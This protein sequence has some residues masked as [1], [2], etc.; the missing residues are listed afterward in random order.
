[1]F[2][3][4]ASSS[5]ASIYCM[6]DLRCTVNPPVPWAGISGISRVRRVRGRVSVRVKIRVRM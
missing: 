2:S 3:T 5:I 1:M 6:I 4:R